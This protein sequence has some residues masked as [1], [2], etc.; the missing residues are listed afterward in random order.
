MADKKD[1]RLVFD[2]M[3]FTV[4]PHVRIPHVSLIPPILHDLHLSQLS[5]NS[6]N[7]RVINIADANLAYGACILSGYECTPSLQGSLQGPQRRMKQVRVDI[8][9]AKVAQ[10]LLQRRCN[11]VLDRSLEA[12]GNRLAEVLS[13]DWCVPMF[14]S[15]VSTVPRHGL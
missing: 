2:P 12:V 10:G 9:R 8:R 7:A 4:S 13:P 5:Q 6:E 14:A 15:E 11:L 3:S 1:Y